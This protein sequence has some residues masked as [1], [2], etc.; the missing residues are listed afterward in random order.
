MRYIYFL[1]FILLIL[2]SKPFELLAQKNVE[3]SEFN[4]NDYNKISLPPLDVLFENARKNPIYE[5]AEVKEQIEYNNLFKEKKAWLNYL[6][7]RGSYQYGM[8]GNES[9][10]TD[11]YTPVFFNY[12]T[13][14]QNSYSLGAGISI[15]LDHLFD[16]RGRVKRQKML[17][18]SAGLEKEL[19]FE[20]IKKEI[21][22]LYSNIL[23][24]LNVL[25]LRSES[26][27]ITSAHYDIAEKNFANGTID[28]GELS[29]EKQR[30]TV[31][32]EQY[33]NTK[34]ELT[35]NILILETISRT[36]LL[37]R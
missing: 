1:I 25:K 27:V 17:V 29:I 16:L 9:T 37:N 10:Y 35:K 30:Q 7:I 19:K 4:I 24:L 2:I 36:P 13:A 6:S 18:K 28:S 5:L 11:V 20:E 14:A 22:V 32:L 31:A 26:L 3:S 12:S 15:P 8:F 33:E 23:S 34:A 21:I